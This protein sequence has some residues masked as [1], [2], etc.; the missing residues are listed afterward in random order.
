MQGRGRVTVEYPSSHFLPLIVD[1]VPVRM[2]PGLARRTLTSTLKGHSLSYVETLRA[3]EVR[4]LSQDWNPGSLAG[5][6]SPDHTLDC[7]VGQVAS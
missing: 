7:P 3:R 5:A 2:L 1:S 4:H 6:G